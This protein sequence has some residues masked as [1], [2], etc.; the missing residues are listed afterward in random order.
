MLYQYEMF[1]I[2]YKY[3]SRFVY[4][5]SKR[6]IT[7]D[8]TYYVGCCLDVSDVRKYEFSGKKEEQM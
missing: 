7:A 1:L 2:E 8:V 3:T 5:H 4:L 6:R